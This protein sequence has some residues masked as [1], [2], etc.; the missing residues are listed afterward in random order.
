MASRNDLHNCATTSTAEPRP[1]HRVESVQGFGGRVGSIRVEKARF[2]SVRFGPC[3]F[4]NPSKT[5]DLLVS[6]NIPGPGL[7]TYVMLA[8]SIGFSMSRAHKMAGFCRNC[9]KSK[10]LAVFY[11]NPCFQLNLVEF[12][13][14]SKS[15]PFRTIDN[16]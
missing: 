15:D 13:K 8:D 16:P 6:H 7:E 2:G 4:Q 11:R 12:H 3:R 10:I 5:I 14:S 9:G 1:S